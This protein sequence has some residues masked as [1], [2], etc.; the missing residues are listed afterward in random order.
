M[1]MPIHWTYD[2]CDE[3]DEFRIEEHWR[4]RSLELEGKFAALDDQP[5][6]LRIAVRQGEDSP[7][8]EVQA[9]LHIDTRTLVAES[10]ASKMERALDMV[11][12]MLADKLDRLGEKPSSVT[13]RSEG[14]P[15]VIHLL[16]QAYQSGQ[17]EIF[18]STLA[19]L[20]G[21]VRAYARRELHMRELE[22]D[23]PGEQITVAEVLNEVM[24][25]AW[26]QFPHRPETQ[27]IALWLV[28]LV[29]AVLGQFDRPIGKESLDDAREAPSS[30]TREAWRDEWIE[31]VGEDETIS[32]GD[33]VPGVESAEVWDDYTADEKHLRLADLAARLPRDCRQAFA[34]HAADGFGIAEIAD[35]QGRS[36]EAVL[37]DIASARR[38]IKAHVEESQLDEIEESMQRRSAS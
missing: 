1:S 14:S 31:R 18:L 12:H 19:P 30:D 17:S 6:E 20:A 33:L 32:L 16:R 5:T 11:L 27:A 4:S 10:S 35:F 13:T 23:L 29:D 7:E 3:Q 15:D 24:V 26:E 34:L 21:S 2:G 36:E 25:R 38:A 37:A 22:D 8:W 9:A 28:G